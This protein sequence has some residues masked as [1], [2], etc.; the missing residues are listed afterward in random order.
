MQQRQ[1]RQRSDWP[2]AKDLKMSAS[3]SSFIDGNAASHILQELQALRQQH[4]DMQQFMSWTT[5]M[6]TNI[7]AVLHANATVEAAE[8]STSNA[9]SKPSGQSPTADTSG[10]CN[11]HG[12]SQPPSQTPMQRPPPHGLSP[13]G[14]TPSLQY[15]NSFPVPPSTFIYSPSVNPNTPPGMLPAWQTG[16][17]LQTPKSDTTDTSP[18]HKSNLASC[19]STLG[20]TALA[21][22][23]GKDSRY[24]K[25]MGLHPGHVGVTTSDVSETVGLLGDRSKRESIRSDWSGSG[26]GDKSKNKHTWKQ[27]FY[28]VMRCCIMLSFCSACHD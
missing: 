23:H 18:G 1:A 19:L 25:G 17:P 22:E 2:K 26:V 16:M 28:K 21:V 12:S 13:L 6:L 20:S 7:E 11:Q 14:K 4:N 24:A 27:W 15:S 9:F 8:H 10:N 5:S 3:M